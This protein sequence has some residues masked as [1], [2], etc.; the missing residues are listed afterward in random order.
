MKRARAAV[1]HER[2]SIANIDW[3]ISDSWMALSAVAALVRRAGTE[4][5][6]HAPEVSE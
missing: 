4:I 5:A 2:R 6:Q 1:P 3:P